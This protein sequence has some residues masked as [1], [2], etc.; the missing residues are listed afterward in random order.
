MPRPLAWG[1]SLF[2]QPLVGAAAQVNAD[3]LVNLT[4]SDTITV[5]RLVIQ[6][7]LTTDNVFNVVDGMMTVDLGVQVVTDQA[8]TTGGSATPQVNVAAA[9]PARGWLWRY[10]GIVINAVGTGPIDFHTAVEVRADIRTMRKVDRGKLILSMITGV[11]HGTVFN[12]KV[13]G[14]VRVFCMT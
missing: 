5:A 14:I 7:H 9:S 2:A 8:F 11:S 1:D 10:R 4:P 3:L 13:T 12:T 6:L